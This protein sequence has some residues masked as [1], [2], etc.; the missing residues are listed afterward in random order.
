MTADHQDP[1]N[2]L[3][4]PGNIW[5]NLGLIIVDQFYR[6]VLLIIKGTNTF[7][8]FYYLLF[9]FILYDICITLCWI[10]LD[11]SKEI[12]KLLCLLINLCIFILLLYFYRYKRKPFLHNEFSIKFYL[13]LFNNK[14]L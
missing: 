4:R 10:C 13:I 11:L 7:I 8:F 6:S 2:L 14:S 3:G 9:L 1:W 12:S 5:D